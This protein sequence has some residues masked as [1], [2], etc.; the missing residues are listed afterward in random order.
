MKTHR[1]YMHTCVQHLQVQQPNL[2]TLDSTSETPCCDPSDNEIDFSDSE[3]PCC[4]PSGNETDLSDSETPC[5]D[6][7]DGREESEGPVCKKLKQ[8]LYHDPYL[9][10]EGVATTPLYEGAT[11]TVLQTLAHYFTWFTEHPGISKDALSSMLSLLHNSILPPGNFLPDTYEAALKAVQSYLVQPIVYHVCPNDCIIFRGSFVDL[12]HCP[13]CHSARYVSG[14]SIPA[15]TFTYLPLGPRL[16]RL[17]GTSNLAQ[18]VQTHLKEK[19]IDEMNDIQDSPS[20]SRAYSLQGVFSGDSRGLS[21]ALCTDGVN[22]INHN[23]VSHSMW[24]I[25]LTNL[26]LP[27]KIRNRFGNIL[28]VVI[29]PANKSKEPH[30]LNPYLDIL[31]DELLEITGSTVFDAYRNAPFTLKVEL[32]LYILDYPGILC[33][34]F[35]IVGSGAYNGCAWCHIQGEPIVFVIV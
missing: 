16:A 24:P 28:L 8:Q 14:T 30:N 33:K 10:E 22:P 6:P 2:D 3:T 23:K 25:M 15:R 27:R 7:S 32:L 13:E 31:V 18:V 5:C 34:L 20:W 26:N 12:L 17:F 29:V 4:D 1:T 9:Y 19:E 11:I 35:G 21:L